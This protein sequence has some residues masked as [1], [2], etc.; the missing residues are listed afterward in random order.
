[1]IM[2]SNI[3]I[4]K[5]DEN[6]FQ[7][8]SIFFLDHGCDQDLT[9]SILDGPRPHRHHT[10]QTSQSPAP[11]RSHRALHNISRKRDEWRRCL[12]AS[13]P[14]LPYS[15][16]LHNAIIKLENAENSALARR[17]IPCRLSWH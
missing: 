16:P 12:T 4:R 10:H 7:N 5:D 8:M 2:L 15:S 6:K 11:A 9:Y 14:A 3:L 1:M 17:N 13:P